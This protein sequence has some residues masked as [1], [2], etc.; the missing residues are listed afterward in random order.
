MFRAQPSGDERTL[1]ALLATLGSAINVAP[2]QT[3]YVPSC[4]LT[5]RS[6]VSTSPLLANLVLARV[7]PRYFVKRFHKTCSCK[8][9]NP[10]LEYSVDYY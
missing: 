8:A 4:T 6:T 1:A 9:T 5:K 7:F 3:G 10:A 2:C